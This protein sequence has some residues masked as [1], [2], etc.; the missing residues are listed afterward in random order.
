MSSH[1]F[2]V[3]QGMIAHLKCLVNSRDKILVNRGWIPPELKD[4][5][6]RPGTHDEESVV[7]RG[8]LRKSDPHKVQTLT[9][10]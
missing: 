5:S 1:R 7:L 3:N 8:L 10:I 6:L 4:P 9:K 2:F